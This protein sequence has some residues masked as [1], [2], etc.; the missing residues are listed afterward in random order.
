MGYLYLFLPDLLLSVLMCYLLFA[1][2]CFFMLMYYLFG[3]HF[4]LLFDI[5]VIFVSRRKKR[6]GS[7]V[8]P[9]S[10]RLKK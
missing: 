8:L 2:F 10:A 3:L 1:Y 7:L 6:A 5:V 9:L 4:V